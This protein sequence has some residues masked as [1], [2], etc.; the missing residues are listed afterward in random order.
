[1][2]TAATYQ[3]NKR[4]IEL[5]EII[6]NLEEEKAQLESQINEL[7]EQLENLQTGKET[8]VAG[9]S[10]DADRPFFFH[11][12]VNIDT[13]VVAHTVQD[14]QDALDKVGLESIEF[15]LYRRDFENWLIDV[16]HANTLASRISTIRRQEC[17][18]NLHDELKKAVEDW[19][20]H[21]I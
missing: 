3:H 13:G 15:H 19:L 5:E 12:D 1:M 11:K 10:K 17:R 16:F 4:R 14:L 21:S 6:K 20:A 9:L 7:K 8:L 18:S 2:E